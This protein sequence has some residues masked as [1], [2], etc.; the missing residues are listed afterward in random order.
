[1]PNR[2]DGRPSKSR[3]IHEALSCPI[4]QETIGTSAAVAA[5]GAPSMQ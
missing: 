1:M 5:A 3:R 4:C 2:P